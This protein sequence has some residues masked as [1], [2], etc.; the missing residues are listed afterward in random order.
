MFTELSQAW[1]FLEILVES[2][3]EESAQPDEEAHHAAVA[4]AACRAAIKAN[5]PLALPE[6]TKL[7]ADLASCERPMTCPHGRPTHIRLPIAELHRRFRRT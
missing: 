4:R 7:L 3:E 1:R 2:L 6:M 5:D